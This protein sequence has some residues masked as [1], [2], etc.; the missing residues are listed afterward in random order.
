M[1]DIFKDPKVYA[2]EL[3]ENFDGDAR[4]AHYAFKDWYEIN[5]WPLTE[6]SSVAGK[7]STAVLVEIKRV[8]G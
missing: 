2:T 7:W 8:V 4:V 6:V 3:I 1:N 5:K